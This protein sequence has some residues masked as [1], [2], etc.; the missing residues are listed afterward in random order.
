[1]DDYVVRF[2]NDIG[3]VERSDYMSKEQA[4]RFYNKIKLDIRTTWKELLYE[5]LEKEDV[6]E[7][8]KSDSIKIV[9]LGICKMALPV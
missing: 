2:G 7:I 4:E 9:D 3:Y 8:I 6:Q 1:M 5:P